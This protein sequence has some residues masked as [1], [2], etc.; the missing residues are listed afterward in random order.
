[1][2]AGRIYLLQPES[3]GE[4]KSGLS[5]VN[6]KDYATLLMSCMSGMIFA[7]KKKTHTR[8]RIDSRILQPAWRLQ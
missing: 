6:T 2:A 4:K 7:T 8:E 3:C 5:P 1:M